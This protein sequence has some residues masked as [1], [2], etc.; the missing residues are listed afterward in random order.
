MMLS[1]AKMTASRHGDHSCFRATEAPQA[2]G[3]IGFT[4]Y[5]ISFKKE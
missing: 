5:L 2:Q 4:S 3:K 1:L